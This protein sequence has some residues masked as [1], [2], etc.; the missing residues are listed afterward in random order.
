[1]C[2]LLALTTLHKKN[3]IHGDIKP[4]NILIDNE[5]YFKIADFSSA[6]FYNCKN[7]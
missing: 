4:E 1:V 2:I 5:G 3:I 7:T 6:R